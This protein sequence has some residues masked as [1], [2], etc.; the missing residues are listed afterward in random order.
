V[1]PHRAGRADGEARGGG[2]AD[3]IALRH[4]QLANLAQANAVC[5]ARAQER[6][7]AEQT[8][9]DAKGRERDAQARQTGANPRGRPPTPPT[10]GPRDKDQDHG[11]DP[12][13]RIRKNSHNDGFAHH[14]HAQ[15]AVAQDRCLL[16]ASTLST[17]PNDPAAALPTLDAIPRAW[18]TPQA[19]ALD[20]GD[21]SAT[22]IAAMAARDLAPSSATGRTPHHPRWPAYCAQQPAPP[23]AEASPKVQMA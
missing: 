23:P 3:A 19:G 9:Y 16:V 1:R 11:T 10:P 18:G 21:C 22:N 17:H 5:E 4:E 12:E 8:A 20:N 7:A 14:D 2:I 13:S 6:S 15:A